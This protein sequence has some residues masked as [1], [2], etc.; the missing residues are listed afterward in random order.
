ML[1]SSNF[2]FSKTSL[3][4]NVVNISF[5]VRVC[6]GTMMVLIGTYGEVELVRTSREAKVATEAFNTT[7]ALPLLAQVGV[8]FPVS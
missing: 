1:V 8:Y 6:E 4:V 5:C 7:F 3:H 2:L